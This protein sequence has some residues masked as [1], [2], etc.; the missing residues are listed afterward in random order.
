VTAAA[1]ALL[2]ML[3]AL[4]SGPAAGE[5][6]TPAALCA[7]GPGAF[8]VHYGSRMKAEDLERLR[9]F[10]IVVS[11][12]VLPAGQVRR[13]TEAGSALFV[14]AWLTGI[15]GG[16]GGG[17]AGDPDGAL[18]SPQASRW[19]L[20]PGRPDRGPDRQDRAYYYDPFHAD[21][22]RARAA[23]WA[24]TLERASYRGVFFDL[25]GSLHV[26]AAL[27]AEYRRR[28]PE[29]SYDAAL[30]QHLRALRQRR[31]GALVFTNQ[32]YR[33][34][35]VYLPLA[36]YDLTES[37]MTSYEGGDTV[38][39]LVDGEGEV[40][41]AQTFYRPWDELGP[42]LDGIDV[43]VRRYHP[44]LRV[45]H[46]NYV[47]PRLVPTGRTR[48]VGGTARPVYRAEVNRPA[49]HYGYA[50]AKLWGHESFTALAPVHAVH[51]DIYLADLG[52]PLDPGRSEQDG[53]VR[54]YYEHGVV[55]VNPG[56]VSRTATLRARFLPAGVTDLWDC[57]E[58]RAVGGLAVTVAPTA[59]VPGG[60]VDPAG[61]VYMYVR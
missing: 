10:R 29:P 20:N 3:L 42:I 46:L 27:R 52:R 35:E 8:A 48:T 33:I 59:S 5:P 28:H 39:V 14:Y 19:L 30:A 53:L 26:P 32:G 54:R 38:R 9:R 23:R 37:L 11:G 12:D 47:T 21:L 2:A 7:A 1:G 24:G 17:L 18:G 34:P 44:A 55:V 45:F 41:H 36:D 61:R 6:R 58:R 56:P 16:D 4:P 43:A 60:G 51:D 50:A 15:Y 31:P 57:Y 22:A 49:I 13:F 40:S 25:V